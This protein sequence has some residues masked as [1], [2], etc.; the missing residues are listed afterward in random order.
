MSETGIKDQI[1]AE[2]GGKDQY[3]CIIYIY[4]CTHMQG[5]IFIISQIVRVINI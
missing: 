3:I 5:N 2:T 4:I 1:L